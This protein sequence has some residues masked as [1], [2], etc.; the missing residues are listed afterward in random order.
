MTRGEVGSEDLLLGLGLL[1]ASAVLLL[2]AFSLF[3]ST[4]PADRGVLLQSCM[5][6]VSGDISTVA[7]SSIPYK[8]SETYDLSGISLSISSDYVTATDPS[9][10]SFARPLPVRVSPG[11]YSCGSLFWN[12]TSDFKAFN[13]RAFGAE[14]TQE[15]PIDSSDQSDFNS[16]QAASR[17][18][19]AANPLTINSTEPVVIEKQFVYFRNVSTGVLEVVPCVFVYQ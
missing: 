12:D 19:L 6:E 15:R 13:T 1:L 5:A 7:S 4:L 17:Q 9:G 11:R 14:G 10:S 18:Y 16:I 8:H 3:R 2:V